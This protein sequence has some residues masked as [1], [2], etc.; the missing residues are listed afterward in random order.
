MKRGRGSRHE[1][2]L[3]KLNTNDQ[4]QRT[5]ANNCLFCYSKTI[6]EKLKDSEGGE[7]DE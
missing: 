6:I 5:V 3:K 4:R 1:T 7:N 2:T